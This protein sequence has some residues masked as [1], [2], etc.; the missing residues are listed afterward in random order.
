MC[1]MHC[2]FG[3]QKGSDGCDICKC[4]DAPQDCGIR[5]MCRKYCENGF[6]T[7]SDGCEICS[8]A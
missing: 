6:R 5:P 4:N 1:A 3:F 2:E 7:G 8:C